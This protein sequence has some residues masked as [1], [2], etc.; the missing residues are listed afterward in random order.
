MSGL[1]NYCGDLRSLHAIEQ[2]QNRGNLA[3]WRGIY[4]SSSALLQGLTSLMAWGVKKFDS[5]QAATLGGTRRG[6]ETRHPVK[7]AAGE[8]GALHRGMAGHNS[9]ETIS[10][11]GQDT[12]VGALEELGERRRRELIGQ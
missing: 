1:W 10:R 6:Q 3:R 5:I 8:L 4:A 11:R 12:L 7:C 2:T 9:M